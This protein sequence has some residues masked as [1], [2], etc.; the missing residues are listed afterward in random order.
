MQV[1]VAA[2]RAEIER[3]FRGA[4]VDAAR[5]HDLIA[6]EFRSSEDAY[7]LA[8]LLHGKPWAD[9]PV[10][11]LF[12]HRSMLFALTPEAYRAYVPAYLAAVLR[13]DEGNDRYGADLREYLMFSLAATEGDSDARR[14]LVTRRIAALDGEQRAVA[15]AVVEYLKEH[16]RYR[17]A[18]ADVALANLA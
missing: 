5:P 1:D 8:A 17:A 15:R 18:D 9:V 3:A 14:A 2:L 12:R 11:E 6:A 13:T 7:E 10:V 4:A 16:W